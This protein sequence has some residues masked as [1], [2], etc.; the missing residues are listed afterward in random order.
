[1]LDHVN[2]RYRARNNLGDRPEELDIVYSLRSIPHGHEDLRPR[3]RPRHAREEQSL[4]LCTHFAV[5][6]PHVH[7]SLIG[8]IGEPTRGAKVVV[9]VAPLL[10]QHA[11]GRIDGAEHLHAW[12]ILWH[13]N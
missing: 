12:L 1:M 4:P 5:S 10:P 6:V 9:E 13:M 11:P 8:P 3:P 7:P 2:R